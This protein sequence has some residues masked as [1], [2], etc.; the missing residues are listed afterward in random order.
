[1]INYRPYINNSIFIIAISVFYVV[2]IP[3]Y[4]IENHFVASIVH[5]IEFNLTDLY[6]VVS[7]KET[8]LKE[9]VIGNISLPNVFVTLIETFPK[10]YIYILL[11][12]SYYILLSII[13]IITLKN[14]SLQ[15]Q[16]AKKII[17][18]EDKVSHLTK[19]RD[20][21]IKLQKEILHLSKSKSIP[22][23]DIK[24]IKGCKKRILAYTRNELVPISMQD[25]SCVYVENQTTYIL[26]K[27]GIKSITNLTLSDIYNCLDKSFF[28][29]VNRQVI[30]SISSI[31]RILKIDE[32][33]LKIEIAPLLEM[34]ILIGKNK[35]AQFKKWLDI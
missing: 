34:E 12:A 1:M 8:F 26:R 16:F 24:P 25:I 10:L 5:H 7:L 11:I 13:S 30:I 27:D 6:K 21:S 3:L 14:W 19:S 33:K 9:Y 29:K 4:F 15:K 22:E 20:F 18:L 17:K 35:V 31:K 32:S 23:Y 28:F 2:L